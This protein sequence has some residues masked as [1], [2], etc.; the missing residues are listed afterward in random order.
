MYRKNDNIETNM[1][2][3][4]SVSVYRYNNQWMIVDYN[5]FTPGKP[6]KGLLVVLEQ[7]P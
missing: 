2:V 7:I 4:P 5:R 3:Y 6:D 1:S